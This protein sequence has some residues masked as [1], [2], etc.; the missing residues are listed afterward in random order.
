MNEPTLTYIDGKPE[1]PVCRDGITLKEYA[2]RTAPG[3][4]PKWFLVC[5][6]C[7]ISLPAPDSN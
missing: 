2:E 4:K 6:V 5:P 1:C 3:Q 7:E